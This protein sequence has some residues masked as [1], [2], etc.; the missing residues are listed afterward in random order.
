MRTNSATGAVLVLILTGAAYAFGQGGDA[1]DRFFRQQR[2]LDEQLRQERRD[3]APLASRVDLQYGGWLEY[4]AFHYDDGVQ[5]SREVHRPGLSVWARLRIDDGA[6]EL[7]ARARL[8]YTYFDPGDEI[9]RQEDW[10]GPNFDQAWYQIDVGRAFRLN[11]PGD[12]LQLRAR[13]GRQPVVLGTGFIMDMPLDAVVLDAGIYDFR[14]RGLFGKSIGSYP[15]IDRSEPVDSHSDRLFYGVQLS[16][17]GWQKHVPFV[18]AMW[19]NDRTDERPKDLFQNYSYD[20]FY[21]GFGA[22]GELAPNFNY[23]AEGVYECGHSFGDGAFRQQDRIEA[24]GWDIGVE[25]LFK[26]RMKPRI[27]AEYMFGS[28]DP[29]RLFS[30]HSAAGGNRG[31]RKDTSLVGF[32]FRDTGIALAPTVSNLHVWRLGGSISPLEQVEFLRHLEIGTNW[33]LYHKNSSRGAISDPLADSF[34]GYVGWE[35]DYYLNWRLASDLSWTIR[36][37]TFFPGSAFS[38]RDTRHMVFTGVTWS[39]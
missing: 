23:W 3:K 9:R 25:K 38:D 26:G 17:E 31:D 14:V 32:G 35:M 16:Y 8:R 2:L 33:F 27:V 20:S 21:A 15:N 30:P 12:P 29:D 5:N 1:E 6:H 28:G 24:Y 39:F 11:E 34:D 37:G 36:W 22:R 18:Y 19:N 4:Y 7:F 10:W 13:I